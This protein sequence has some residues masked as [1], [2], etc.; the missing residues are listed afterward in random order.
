[1]SHFLHAARFRF[2]S[3][4][5]ARRPRDGILGLP[6]L[7]IM[8]LLVFMVIH[9]R[10]E[11][12]GGQLAER[13]KA[14]QA[15]LDKGCFVEARIA[16]MRLTQDGALSQKALLIEAKAL[17]GMGREREALRL[18]AREAPLDHP[19][20][21][22]AHVLQAAILLAQAAPDLQVVRQHLRHALQSDPANPDAHEFAARF[23]AARNDW[24]TALQH[25]HQIGTTLRPD[26]LL[27]QATAQQF[28]GQPQQAV[29]TARLAETALRALHDPASPEAE[30]VR[31]SIAVSLSLQRQFE[32]AIQ[33]ILS[34][35]QGAPTREERQLI[36]GIYLS[37]SRHLKEPPAADRRAALTL[38]EQGIQISP[39]SQDLIMAF[40]GDCAE[41][42]LSAIERDQHIHRVLGGGGGI[43]SSFLH[44]H[45]GIQD[46]QQGRRDSARAHF[47]LAS[48]L[49]PGFGVISNNLAMALAAVSDQHDDLDRAL[50]IM[51]SLLR[52]EPENPSY[53]DTR[54]RVL[55]RLGQPQAAIR[56]LERSLPGSRDKTSAHQKIAELY[57]ALQMPELAL[58][59]QQAATT[60]GS[61]T[62]PPQAMVENRP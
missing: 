10:L 24:K 51:D 4:L 31:F 37:W 55:A 19:G 28:T 53:L 49:N 35:I 42:P 30:R 62:A 1:M 36:G 18:L 52:Q 48:T 14:A 58:A 34:S 2:R 6:A 54:G 29:Q 17:R 45:L 43:A 7:L 20:H 11:A 41:Q 3:I 61:A 9:S 46:W 16:A 21:A 39:D 27:M 5:D 47:E 40:L 32:N 33:W 8:L 26:L 44:H 56:D 60:T 22:P 15:H 12:D 25:L 59:H 13:E 50:A 57:Q 38:L 23:A